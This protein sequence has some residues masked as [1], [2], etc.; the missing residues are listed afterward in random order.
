[1]AEKMAASATVATVDKRQRIFDA[2][3]KRNQFR[4]DALIEVLQI[5]RAHV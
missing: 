3:L 1:M 4:Q 2:A 5:G